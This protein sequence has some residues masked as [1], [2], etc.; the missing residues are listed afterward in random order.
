MRGGMEPGRKLLT[1]GLSADATGDSSY[2]A[3]EGEGGEKGGFSEEH[4]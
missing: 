4:G 1:M 2:E 3:D